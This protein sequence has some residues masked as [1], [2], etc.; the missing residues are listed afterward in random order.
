[1]NYQ[2]IALDMDGTLLNDEKK[3]TEKTLSYIKRAKEKGVKVVISSGRVPGGLKFYEETI[4]KEEPMICANGALILNDKK[5]T[6]YNE[7][8][9]KNIL[10]DIID[11]LRKYKNTYYHF[12]HDNI[13]CTEKFDYSTKKFYEFNK[14]IER[15]YRIEIRI[16]TDSK[17]Y[18]KHRSSEI[19]KIVVVDNDLEYLNRIQKEI[20]DNLKVSVTKSHISNIE[21]CNFGI[22][23][24]IALEKL[25]NYYNIPIEKC[26]AVG[27]DENDISM[28]KKAGL[29]VFM[30]NT[31]EEL[32][33]YADYVTYMDN[34]NDGIAEVIEKFI[35]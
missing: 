31:R 3:I 5:E 8:I 23:K 15:K 1:M 27:N 30:K 20:E 17:E 24:G 19:T 16:I 26:I 22:S 13:M 10:L 9:N 28:I 18:I 2:L 34:N 33:K 29:G 4:A 11:I 21:I 12:Y 25:A 32:K 35:L 7:G 6:I 14:N